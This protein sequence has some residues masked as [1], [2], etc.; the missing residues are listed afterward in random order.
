MA[1]SL[2][3]KAEWIS[4]L[5]RRV[6]NRIQKQEEGLPLN[7]PGGWRGRDTRTPVVLYLV[8][9]LKVFQEV[10]KT[11]EAAFQLQHFPN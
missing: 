7:K 3:R 9:L 11:Q 8:Y 6:A 1:N 5:T 4:P 10:A 2:L